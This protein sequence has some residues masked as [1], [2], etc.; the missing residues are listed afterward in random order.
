[1]AFTTSSQIGVDLNNA[2]STQLF[3]LNQ[4]VLGSDDS[5]W[6]YVVATAALVTGQLVAIQPQGTAIPLST[7]FVAAST[8][9]LD[10]GVAQFPISS[11]QYGFV[12]KKGTNLYILCSGTVPPTTQVAF[13]ATSGALVT[14]L[15]AAVGNT[16]AGIYITTSASTAGLSCAIGIVT[17]PRAAPAT[18]TTPMS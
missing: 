6:Q 10:I 4:S 11:T 15:L 18:S 3:T 16:A 5:L 13:S 17:F 12:A 14:S 1:M 9:G 7:G 8:G 2:S